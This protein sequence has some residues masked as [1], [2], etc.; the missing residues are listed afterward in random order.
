MYVHRTVTKQVSV[1]VILTVL[2]NDINRTIVIMKMPILV[3]IHIMIIIIL[4]VKTRK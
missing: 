1:V 4:V 2:W 3:I